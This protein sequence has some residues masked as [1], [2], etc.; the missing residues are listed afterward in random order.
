[1]TFAI[2]RAAASRPANRNVFVRSDS[3]DVHA[4][5]ARST[6]ER[7]NERLAAHVLARDLGEDLVLA[8][9]EDTVHQL[10]VF[11]H[12][13]RQHDDRDA[14]LRQ[15]HE[16]VVDVV[17]RADVHSARRIVEEKHL[18]RSSEP[19]CEDN[20]LL[21]TSTQRADVV[22]RSPERDAEEV[23][24]FAEPALALPRADNPE[25]CV[26]AKRGKREVAHGS[27]SN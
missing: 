11:V 3:P 7:R 20:L 15:L 9:H 27:S 13:R 4:R 14:F 2:S 21:V 8:E 6:E 25:S 17:L 10:D 18:R 26:V 23:D 22:G 19:A 1:M 16:E 5:L 24:P 12:F